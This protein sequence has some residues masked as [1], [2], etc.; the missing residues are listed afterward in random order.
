MVFQEQSYQLCRRIS[1][2]AR[3]YLATG[4]EF[5]LRGI[6]FKKLEK[7][8][9]RLYAGECDRIYGDAFE[10]R[11]RKIERIGNNVTLE[12]TDLDF[13]ERGADRITLCCHSNQKLNPIQIRFTTKEGS[14][15]QAVEA[16]ES[17]DYGEQ[18]FKLETLKG[19]GKLELIFLP[20]SCFDLEW[21]QFNI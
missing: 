3:I 11:D 16:K 20:G 7:A 9:E 19:K 6:R 1:G 18:T 8:Y 15:V 13:G 5:Q 4:D 21:L 10:R 17:M 2:N 12:F 14:F